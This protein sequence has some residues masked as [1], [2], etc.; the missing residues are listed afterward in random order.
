[1]DMQFRRIARCVMIRLAISVF[2]IT[3]A[4]S[5]NVLPVTA[6]N[7]VNAKRPPGILQVCATCRDAQ[8]RLAPEPAAPVLTA[9]A[10]RAP[11]TLLQ[12]APDE[13]W[14]LVKTRDGLSGWVTRADVSGPLATPRAAS[15]TQPAPKRTRAKSAEAPRA[16]PAVGGRTQPVAAQSLPAP[17]SL[18]AIAAR[19][20]TLGN[21]ADVFAKIGDSL[22]AVPYVMYPIG[23]GT[24]NLHQ[25]SALQPAADYFRNSIVRDGN[26]SFINNSLAAHAGWTSADVLNHAKADP[27]HCFTGETPLSCELRLSKPAVALILFGTNDVSALSAAQY[28]ENMQSIVR[29]TIDAG[30][31]PVLSTIPPRMQF[32]GQCDAFNTIL[33][34]I[35]HE[36]H[37]PLSDYASAM[38]RLPNYGLSDDGVH[39]S[40]PA[41]EFALA[42]D[43]TETHL[44]SGYTLRNLMILQSLD[45][46]WRQALR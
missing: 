8:L 11:L 20:K 2:A 31:I 3:A 38:K 17:T 7:G 42:A 22:T 46:V 19:G 28:R 32:E 4:L 25:H 23:W 40:W 29:T 14:L 10:P 21:R 27:A 16:K 5:A 36:Q 33:A 34:E 9:L 44:N 37:V 45:A 6:S 30:V 41:G 43:F 15:K 13:Q 12:R 26:N 1:M 24:F 18:R 39:P 35:A